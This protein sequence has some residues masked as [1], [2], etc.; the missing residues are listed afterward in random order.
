MQNVTYHALQRENV[1]VQTSQDEE[2]HWGENQGTDAKVGVW[3]ASTAGVAFSAVAEC[4]AFTSTS[5]KC[6]SVSLQ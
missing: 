1:H 6:Q 2:G 3:A 4:V 5:L